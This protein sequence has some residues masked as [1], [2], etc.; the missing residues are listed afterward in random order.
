MHLLD[1]SAFLAYLLDEPGFERVEKVIHGEVGII[2]VNL[3][4]VMFRLERFGYKKSMSEFLKG[5][6]LEVFSYG[7]DDIQSTIDLLVPQKAGLSL[8]DRVC[9]SF[10]KQHNIPVLTADRIW[11]TI[12]K[13]IMVEVIR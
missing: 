2:S 5:T 10:A 1:A 8:A 11:P 9:L 6:N 13:T 3:T 12:D 7:I 4:E